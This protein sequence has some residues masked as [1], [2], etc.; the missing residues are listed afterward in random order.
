MSAYI[1][2]HGEAY[3]L[4]VSKT[5]VDHNDRDL[6]VSGFGLS[7][8]HDEKEI[9][10]RQQEEGRKWALRPQNPL[11]LIRDGEVGGWEFLYLTPT[12]YTVTTRFRWAVV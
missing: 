10:T 6:F 12:R 1:K 7:V 5:W 9:E 4:V 8:R 3:L 11:R 2:G